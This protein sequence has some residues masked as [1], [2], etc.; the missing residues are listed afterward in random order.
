VGLNEEW[1]LC[2]FEREYDMHYV[3]NGWLCEV[4][5]SAYVPVCLLVIKKSYRCKSF[6]D[7]RNTVNVNR[8]TL[9]C[10]LFG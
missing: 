10:L 4:Y 1:N 5:F 2:N 3:L 8:N 6:L 9:F 7:E